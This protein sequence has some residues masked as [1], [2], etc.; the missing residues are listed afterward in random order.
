[1]VVGVVLLIIGLNAS[2]S[3]ADRASDFWT[4]RFTKSTTWYIV[5]GAGLGVLGLLLAAFGRR[6][7]K[8][9]L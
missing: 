8:S 3:L 1:L 9:A 4:G 5:G 6:G 7:S 2:D